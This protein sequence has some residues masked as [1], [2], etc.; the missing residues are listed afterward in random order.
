MTDHE[1]IQQASKALKTKLDQFSEEL[2]IAGAAWLANPD[3]PSTR[4]QLD[5][6]WNEFSQVLMEGKGIDLP[7][8]YTWPKPPQAN[9]PRQE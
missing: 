6:V 9:R 2:Y 7:A 8:G 1:Q 4:E 5:A 3:D